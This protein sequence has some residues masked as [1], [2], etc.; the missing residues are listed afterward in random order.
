LHQYKISK[1][2]CYRCGGLISW[3]NYPSQKWPVHVDENGNKIGTG[4]CPKFRQTT[5]YYKS[6]NLKTVKSATSIKKGYPYSFSPDIRQVYAVFALVAVISIVAAI[7]IQASINNTYGGIYGGPE[8]PYEDPKDPFSWE[9]DC[10]GYASLIVDGDTY[11]F[12]GDTCGVDEYIRLADIDT[13]ESGESGYQAAK[14]YLCALIH[15]KW[16]YL[17]IDDITR[18]DPY[19]RIVGVTY[20]RH[21]STHLLNVNKALVVNGHATIWNFYN[22]EFNPYDWPLYVYHV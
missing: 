5:Q 20:V 12:D 8:Y 15:T 17:D 7:G 3:D 11:F 19:G 1:K 14:D 9:I 10:E 6:S 18:T 16:V 13:P 22:N 21:N 2:R 4:S